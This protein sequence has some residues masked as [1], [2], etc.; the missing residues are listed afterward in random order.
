MPLR[1]RVWT[2][3]AGLVSI[4]VLV[5]LLV[6]AA[7]DGRERAELAQFLGRFHP[8]VVHLPIALLLLVPLL[9]LAALAAERRHLRQSA[10]FVLGLAT[11]AAIGSA[12]LGWL[13]A[14]SGGYEGS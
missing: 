1:V 4:F 8:L 11:A 6:Y 5:L 2:L 12:W 14:W 10:L 3:V 13:L 9:E 7:P